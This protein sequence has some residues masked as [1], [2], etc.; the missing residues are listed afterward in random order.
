[1]QEVDKDA[2]FMSTNGVG[3]IDKSYRQTM[4]IILEL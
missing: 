2:Y 1:M 3:I 4:W